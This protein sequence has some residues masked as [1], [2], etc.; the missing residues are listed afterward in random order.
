MHGVRPTPSRDLLDRGGGNR[1]P[2][3]CFRNSFSNTF[4]TPAVSL[5]DDWKTRSL[6]AEYEKHSIFKDFDIKSC[7][8]FRAKSDK[9]V[10]GKG[11]YT[12]WHHPP[13]RVVF[14]E[15]C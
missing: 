2:A 1:A 13:G 10:K 9:N 11:I 15:M 12:R 5:L 4:H 3:P 14:I 8:L 7:G 6:I